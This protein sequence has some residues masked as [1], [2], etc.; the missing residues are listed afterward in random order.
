V[1]RRSFISPA[2]VNYC[3]S[4]L[5]IIPPWIGDV[6]KLEITPILPLSFSEN[7]PF[8]NFFLTLSF[9]H[10]DLSSIENMASLTLAYNVSS[11]PSG[12]Q[13]T[14]SACSSAELGSMEN[15]LDHRQ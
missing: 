13:L 15:N 6:L 4:Q 8:L 14:I 2:L 3:Q 10:S 12:M 7:L 11:N 1:P 9:F 5:D